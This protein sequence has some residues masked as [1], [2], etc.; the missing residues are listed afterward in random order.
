DLILTCLAKDPSARFTSVRALLEELVE[1]MERVGMSKR[2][3]E[4]PLPTPRRHHADSDCRS[5]VETNPLPMFAVDPE[6][7]FTLV[8]QSFCLFVKKEQEELVGQALGE[9]RLATFCPGIIDDLQVVLR[10][11]KVTSR[12]LEFSVG[13]GR[14][15][16]VLIWLTPLVAS[17]IIIG[18]HGVVHWIQR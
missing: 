9:S 5:I 18:A 3:Q 4:E 17:G 8:N 15:S 6:G 10:K 7:L 13:P 16:K 12:E 14:Q 1:L 2:R 11:N